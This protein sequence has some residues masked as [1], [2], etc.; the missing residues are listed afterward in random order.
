MISCHIP[1][2]NPLHSKLHLSLWTLGLSFCVFRLITVGLRS[3]LVCSKHVKVDFGNNSVCFG[4]VNVGLG[5][6]L[7]C[8]GLV[9]LEVGAV[10]LCLG[11]VKMGP[12]ED[13]K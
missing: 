4:L 7:V 11:F 3:V 5:V 12:R 9:R 2:F 8:C 6:N 10:L 1:I 13:L